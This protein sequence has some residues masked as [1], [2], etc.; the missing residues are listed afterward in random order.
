MSRNTL[1]TT[2]LAVLFALSSG[3]LAVGAAVGEE[4]GLFKAYFLE[5]EEGEYSQA[6]A[7]YDKVLASRASATVSRAARAGSARCRDHLAAEDFATLMPP[8]ALV[9]VEL[10]RPGDALEKLAEMLGLTAESMQELLAERPGTASQSMVRIPS[11]VAISPAIFDHFNQ[12]G[13][14]AIAI[15]NIDFE[16]GPP[17]GVL[18]LHHGDVNLMKGILETAFQFAPTAEKIADM[19][20][21][22]IQAPEVGE[23]VGV[24]TESLLIVGTGRG[25]VEGAVGRLVGTRRESLCARAEL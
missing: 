19:P 18:V 3:P 15:T 14:A 6:K 5:H 4:E 12:F 8:D 22:G 16:G 2:C 20:T 21:F 25:E 11:E 7:L 24:L 9:Y 23:V 13:G 10:N 1:T 17:E